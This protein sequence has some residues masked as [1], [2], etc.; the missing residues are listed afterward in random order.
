MSPETLYLLINA[1]VLPGWF[2]LAFA[3]HARITK[4]LV[5][6]GVYPLI[7]GAIY[8]VFLCAALFFGQSADGAGMSS[9]AGVMALFS[10]PTGVLTGWTH[11]LVFD[12]FIGAWIGRDASRRGVPHFLVI[13][14]LFFT[15]MFG[16]IGLALYI[17]VRALSKK[18]GASLFETA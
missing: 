18:G 2:L 12:L 10:H 1:G 8:A 17:S 14:C 13:P 11:Y 6:S 7:Y 5:H 3:P 16:P 4:G 15:L 9:L